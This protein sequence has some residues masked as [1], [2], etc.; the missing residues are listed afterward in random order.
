MAMTVHRPGRVVNIAGPTVSDT[1]PDVTV[2]LVT[3]FS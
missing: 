3:F 1:T 2:T